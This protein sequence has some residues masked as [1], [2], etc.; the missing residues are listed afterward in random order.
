[1]LFKSIFSYFYMSQ[2][3]FGIIL[4]SERFQ[5]SLRKDFKSHDQKLMANNRTILFYLE[6][7]FRQNNHSE[8]E[9]RDEE[10]KL[11]EMNDE[12][13]PEQYSVSGTRCP[14]Q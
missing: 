1:M 5:K 8:D 12:P 4:N 10:E 14:D 9:S 13:W 6:P 3:I 7:R 2:T 11:D